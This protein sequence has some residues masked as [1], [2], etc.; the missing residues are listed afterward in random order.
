[1]RVV[2]V[3]A[4][5]VVAKLQVDIPASVVTKSDSEELSR[6]I[7]TVAPGREQEADERSD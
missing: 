4:A 1:M 5:I 7:D 2:K 6:R 3:R